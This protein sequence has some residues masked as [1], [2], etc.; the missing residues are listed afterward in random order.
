[1]ARLTRYRTQVQ[2]R[3]F[4]SAA[5]LLVMLLL[6][7]ALPRPAGAAAFADSVSALIPDSTI[8]VEILTPGYSQR[9]QELS[10]KLLIA[11]R[12]R[13][14][15][16]EAY[17][18]R[19]RQPLPWHPNLGLTRAEYQE[20]MLGSKASAYVV[21]Q[22][23]KLT[24][25]RIGN[26]AAWRLHGWGLLQPIDGMVIDAV[27]DVVRLPRRGALQGM[28]IVEPTDRTVSLDWKWYAV[29]KAVHQSGDATRGG[30]GLIL[31]LHMGPLGDGNTGLYWTERHVNMGSA[32][33]DE[34]LLLR[35]P[36]KLR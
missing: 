33:E 22:R 27:H 15:W 19:Y 30:K 1:M 16:F 12:S 24:F 7:L 8:T 29:W 6:A 10:Q 2:R 20:Y 35:F 23:A 21:R 18:A 32:L 34:F 25:T 36:P 31:A 28:G 14:Q 13:P 5:G 17:T 26:M 4:P 11:A 3:A 9:M